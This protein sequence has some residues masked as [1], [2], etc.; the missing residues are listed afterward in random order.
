MGDRTRDISLD[1]GLAEKS[2]EE[3]EAEF[4]VPLKSALTDWRGQSSANRWAKIAEATREAGATV[5]SPTVGRI[6]NAKNNKHEIKTWIKLYDA[7]NI[8]DDDWWV[9]R[10]C[11]GKPQIPPPPTRAKRNGAL[12][13]VVLFYRHRDL[14]AQFVEVFRELDALDDADGTQLNTLLSFS[15][16]MAL[17]MRRTKA[18]TP[19]KA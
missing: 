9:E 16:L 14:A 13:N 7:I 12:N 3:E 8:L 4:F 1:S 17:A 15:H 5:S 19:K 18:G 2:A 11:T 10:G 6:A